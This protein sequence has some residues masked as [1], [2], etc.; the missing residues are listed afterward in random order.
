[1]ATAIRLV[2]AA[3][4]V[5]A[6]SSAPPGGVGVVP[7]AGHALAMYGS[8]K[9]GP[10]FT[11]FEYADPRAPTGGTVTLSALGTFD[12]LNPFTLKGI[13]AAGLGQVFDTLMV[14]SADEPFS[15][16]GLVAPSRTPHARSGWRPARRRAAGRAIRR[17]SRAGSLP[18][19]TAR[20]PAA[21]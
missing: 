11:H 19:R 20:R 9:Y 6:A 13:A 7:H 14:A 12:T 16:Y 18:P 5:L 21:H 10:G 4:L 17:R 3:L 15:Q 2:V 1:M 8:L